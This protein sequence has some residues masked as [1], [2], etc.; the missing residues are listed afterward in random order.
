MRSICRKCLRDDASGDRV[1][2]Q[3]NSLAAAPGEFSKVAQERGFRGI[4]A[5]ETRIEWLVE[6]DEQRLKGK[7]TKAEI[8]LEVEY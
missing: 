5:E 8:R 7:V 3:R 4:G 2:R 6:A 1:V